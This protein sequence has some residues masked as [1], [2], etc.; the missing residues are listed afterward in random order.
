MKITVSMLDVQNIMHK[1]EEQDNEVAREALSKIKDI[2]APLLE[3]GNDCLC[4]PT[5]ELE[6]LDSSSK[7]DWEERRYEIAKAAMH[8][9]LTRGNYDKNAIPQMAIRDADKLIKELKRTTTK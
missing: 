7:I 9:Y 1:L 3:E 2:F 4:P 8:A 6:V 5:C